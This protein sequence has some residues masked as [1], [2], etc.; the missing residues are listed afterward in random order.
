MVPGGRLG[1]A[2]N[3]AELE[4]DAIVAMFSDDQAGT[5]SERSPPERNQVERS[6]RWASSLQ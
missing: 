6:F 1:A 5:S 3:R 4:T 2:L